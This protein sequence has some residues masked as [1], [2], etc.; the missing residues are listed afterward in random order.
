MVAARLS[1]E[2]T[3]ANK[4]MSLLI[5]FFH[6]QDRAGLGQGKES[7]YPGSSILVLRRNGKLFLHCLLCSRIGQDGF[8]F[9]GLFHFL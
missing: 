5:I 9:Y 2:E 6:H 1:K 3:T 8:H 7:D 4:F